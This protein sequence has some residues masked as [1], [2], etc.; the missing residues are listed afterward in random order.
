MDPFGPKQYYY[1]IRIQFLGFRY[2]GW[3]RQPGVK[4][5]QEMVEKTVNYVVG[6]GIK[7]KVL[8]ASRTDAMVSAD[9]FPFELFITQPLK[10]SFLQEFDQ[11]L[12]SDI[13]AR[14]VETVTPSFNVIK[15]VKQ[16]EYHYKFSFGEVKNPFDASTCTH[17]QSDL[18]IECMKIGA[19]TFKGEHNLASYCYPFNV[20]VNKVRVITSCSIAETN[21]VGKFL[22]I[23]VS[24]GFMRYQVR[25][26][27][28]TLF[29]LGKGN[30]TL[31]ELESSLLP[32]S[33]LDIAMKA[34]ASGLR[35]HKVQY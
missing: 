15:D 32:D 16:K 17:L 30:I 23:V 2:H 33:N 1:L 18:D 10:E 7:F 31:Q 4:T 5:I 13:S 3:Q 14:S 22:F 26:M 11:N 28:G 6:D 19:Q 24:S 9:D 25:Y 29:E 12:P 34:P 21:E 20:D 35:L 27:I 8:G